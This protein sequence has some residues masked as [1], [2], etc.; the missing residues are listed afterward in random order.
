MYALV[1]EGEI[2]V[3]SS[4][5]P[6]TATSLA[7]GE[8]ITPTDGIW[9]TEQAIECGWYTVI[10]NI[11]PTPQPGIAYENSHQVID[12]VPTLVW[13]ERPMIP[14]ELAV[15]A[16]QAQLKLLFTSIKTIITDLQNEKARYQ[17]V[18]NKTNA[19]ITGGDTKDVARAAKRIADA[20]I[21]LTKLLKGF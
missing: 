5:I 15:E 8:V 13:T 2:F 12:G 10:E 17:V 21:D 4:S 19:N 14:E 3:I 18:I 9:T 6:P 1:K 16:E 11:Q 20:T 7:T